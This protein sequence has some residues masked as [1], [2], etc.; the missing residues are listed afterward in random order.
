M[1]I[2]NWSCGF[3]M[4]GAKCY[5]EISFNYFST[6]VLFK[7]VVRSVDVELDIVAPQILTIL[8][9]STVAFLLE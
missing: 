3:L 6:G 2:L 1:G 5:H 9:K 4:S 8:H 7:K